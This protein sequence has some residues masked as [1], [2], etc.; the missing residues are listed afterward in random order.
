MTGMNSE[1]SCLQ[2]YVEKGVMMK[3]DVWLITFTN[4]NN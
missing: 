1:N 2:T 3:V 4:A